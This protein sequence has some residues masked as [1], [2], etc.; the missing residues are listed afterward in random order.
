MKKNIFAL[1]KKG[2]SLVET[3][4]ALLLL[5]VAVLSLAL[6][7]IATTKLFVHTADHEG[8]ALLAVSLL[9]RLES[10]E[11]IGT[12]GTQGKYTWTRTTTADAGTGANM[13]N[14]QVT[15]P[16]ATGNRSSNVE[17][18]VWSDEE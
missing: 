1:S 17:R 13:E 5:T 12:G 11:D 6:V 16:S 8:A 14:I 15:W 18:L 10:G 4:L 9:E 2:F 7:P 3:L